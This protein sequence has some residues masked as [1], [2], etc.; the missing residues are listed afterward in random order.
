MQDTCLPTA[1]QENAAASS[2]VRNSSSERASK[3]TH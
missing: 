1:W 3:Q 2:T